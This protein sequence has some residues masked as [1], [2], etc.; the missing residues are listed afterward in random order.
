MRGFVTD[1]NTLL[2]IL[3][4]YTKRHLL[5]KAK[6]AGQL[7]ELLTF[8]DPSEP[9]IRLLPVLRVYLPPG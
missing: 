8:R 6:F 2:D 4:A 3:G 9:V 7:E 1:E 5:S